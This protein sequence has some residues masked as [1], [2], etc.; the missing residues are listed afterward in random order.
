MPCALPGLTS[1]HHP[2]VDV[3][4]LADEVAPCR[5]Q[6]CALPANGIDGIQ[7]RLQHSA[8]AGRLVIP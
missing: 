6:E 7:E 1:Q 3:Q 5:D 4:L 2:V 8:H